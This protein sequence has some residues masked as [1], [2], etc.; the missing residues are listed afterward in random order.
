[1]CGTAMSVVSNDGMSRAPVVR[2]NRASRAHEAKVWLEDDDNYALIMDAF[3]STS[4]LLLLNST[5]QSK[6]LK[7]KFK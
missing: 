3:S 1:M 4:R 5:H 7:L 6:S 2:F